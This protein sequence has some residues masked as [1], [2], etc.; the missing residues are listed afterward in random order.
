M[1]TRVMVY[2]AFISPVNAKTK[3]RL[4]KLINEQV[5]W[6]DNDMKA[7][8]TNKSLHDAYR[9]FLFNNEFARM[10]KFIKD[11]QA[12]KMENDGVFI[13]IWTIRETEFIRRIRENT[14]QTIEKYGE[15]LTK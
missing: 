2:T 12:F 1:L 14:S 9:D 15:L 13:N 3:R 6:F 5:S 7:Y 11:L 4:A 8:P 10:D